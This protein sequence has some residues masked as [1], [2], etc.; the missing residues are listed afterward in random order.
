MMSCTSSGVPRTNSMY[1]VASQ[2]NG[3]GT[4]LSHEC[5]DAERHASAIATN[6][7]AKV[8]NAP[9]AKSGASA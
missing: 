4:V 7:S 1:A 5:D 8:S 6:E 3:R 9:R 2:R